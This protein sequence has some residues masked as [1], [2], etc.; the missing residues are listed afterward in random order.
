VSCGLPGLSTEVA[1]TISNFAAAES[2]ARDVVVS[3]LTMKDWL[4]RPVPVVNE[5]SMTPF[6]AAVH[7]AHVDASQLLIG[8]LLE[9][10]EAETVPEPEGLPRG[11]SDFQRGASRSAEVKRIVAIIGDWLALLTAAQSDAEVM[12]D[13]RMGPFLHVLRDEARR[14]SGQVCP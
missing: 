13:P 2:I 11:M 7:N 6:G 5:P 12:Q 14:A 4:T 10:L 8:G 9:A 1:G 3:A